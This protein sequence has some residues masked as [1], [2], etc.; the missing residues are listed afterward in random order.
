M[1]LFCSFLFFLDPPKPEECDICDN[2]APNCYDRGRHA[3][4]VE[5]NKVDRVRLASL[6]AS[7]LDQ[8][9]SINRP[10]YLAMKL[11]DTPGLFFYDGM[12]A[13]GTCW[14]F[15]NDVYA[16]K[17]HFSVLNYFQSP[18]ESTRSI[19]K[20]LTMNFPRFM[21]MMAKL[22]RTMACTN[23]NRTTDSAWIG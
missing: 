6:A 8:K 7:G 17:H 10:S 21:E 22:T 20:L 4:I 12:F 19:P 14:S 5:T 16:L 9:K 1:L 15:L 18:M 23:P 3:S 13:F 11:M 2:A